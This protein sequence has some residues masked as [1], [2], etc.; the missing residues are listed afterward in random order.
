MKRHKM[1]NLCPTSFEIASKMPNFSKWIRR[2]LLEE[3]QR[4][5][6][7]IKYMM[8]CPD[9]DECQRLYDNVPRFTPYCTTCNLQME[10]KWVN[11]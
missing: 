9:H 7:S 11:V 3:D 2:K 1:V 4:N 5:S 10:G 8:W 6:Y